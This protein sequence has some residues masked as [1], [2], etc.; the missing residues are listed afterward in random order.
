MSRTVIDQAMSILMGRQRCTADQAFD[1]LRRRSQQ[2][3]QKLRDV[4][5]DLI[6]RATGQTPQPGKPFDHT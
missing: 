5:A 1:L 3:Q 4:A 2:S 6:V